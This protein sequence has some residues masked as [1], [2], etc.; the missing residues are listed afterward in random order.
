[1]GT[2]DNNLSLTEL[3]FR[4]EILESPGPVL[5]DFWA[6]WCAPCHRIAPV[7]EELASDFEGRA[8]VGKINVDDYP[9]LA[10]E[11]GI[12]SIPSL[13]FFKDGEVV[14]RMSGVMPKGPLAA[15]L[16]SLLSD[17]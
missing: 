10:A 1:M 2:N 5:V 9:D 4:S 17:A 14:H 15:Q 11:H 3:D 12:R 8:R 16:E 7:I 6:E 13:L